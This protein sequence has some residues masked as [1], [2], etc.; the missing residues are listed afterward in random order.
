[1][2]REA[3]E[4][5][6]R[7]GGGSRVRGLRRL[8]GATGSA[9]IGKLGPAG[10]AAS[11]RLELPL[12]PGE[13]LAGQVG[14]LGRLVL[15]AHQV[16]PATDPGSRPMQLEGPDAGMVRHPQAHSRLQLDGGPA[17]GPVAGQ[18]PAVGQEEFAR[19][20]APR[21]I[22]VELE[23]PEDPLAA[24]ERGLGRESGGLGHYLRRRAARSRGGGK[25]WND[26]SCNMPAAAVS[27]AR[28]ARLPQPKP[29]AEATHPGRARA[30]GDLPCD[31]TEP[32]RA[33]GCGV[34]SCPDEVLA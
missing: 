23:A 17:A 6:Q 12:R 7:P 9:G 20:E 16:A 11:L 31:R 1:G 28:I 2:S 21:R 19:D 10:R 14:E 18:Q 8:A 22:E 26:A 25:S 29:E 15:A 32:N 30:E 24:R 13:S 33:D 4:A 34:R 27:F 5:E 3:P